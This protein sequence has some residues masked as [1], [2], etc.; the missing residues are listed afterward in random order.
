M[1]DKSDK[2]I[3]KEARERFKLAID[4]EADNRALRLEDRKFYAGDSDNCYQWPDDIAKSRRS[5]ESPRPM[6]TINKLPA[7]VKQVTNDIRQNRPQIKVRAVDDG[8]DKRTADVFNGLIRHIEANSNADYAYDTAAEGAAVDGLGYWR[9]LTE[10]VDD[11][12]MVQDIVI[13]RVR[14]SFSVYP[15]PGDEP[16]GSDMPWCFITTMIRRDEAKR[17]SKKGEKAALKSWEDDAKE[18]PQWYGDE[19]VRIAEYF[20]VKTETVKV[21]VLEDGSIV[22]GPLPDGTK[23]ARSRDAER[24]NVYWYKL[25]ADEVIEEREWPGKWIPIVRVVGEEID[26]DG[27]VIVKGLVR[28]AKDPQRQYNLSR[29]SVA[30]RINLAPKSPWLSPLAAI[31]GLEKYWEKSNTAALAYL[32]YNHVGEDGEEIPSPTRQAPPDVP[33]GFVQDAII[34]SDDLK[35]VTGQFDASMGQRS[36]ETS[37]KAIIARQKEGDTATF[38]FVDNLSRGIRHTGRILVDLVPKIYDTARVLRILGEDGSDSEVEIDPQQEKSVVDVKDASGDV[39]TIYNLGVGRFDVTV[40]TGPSFSTKRQEAAETLT[41]MTQANPQ[42]MGVIGDLMVK[43]L[44]IH[45]SD[46]MAKRLKATLVPEVREIAEMEG[47][48]SDIPPEARMAIDRLTQQLE[49]TG[50]QI[51]QIQDLAK[52]EIE[53]LEKEVSK[54]QFDVEKAELKKQEESL[55]ARKAEIELSLMK[56]QDAAQ[57]EIMQGRHELAEEREI[58]MGTGLQQVEQVITALTNAVAQMVQ[59]QAQAQMQ[60][61]ETLAQVLTVM[62]TPKQITVV[63][64]NDGLIAGATQT[65]MLQ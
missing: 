51:Q 23:A 18:N 3:I 53:K 56:T 47:K 29:S 33:V 63:R 19:R 65:P 50:Q 55:N 17:M 37:G 36:N 20:C 39:S 8:A 49:Q 48:K 5:K 62:A 46:E 61:N 44:D 40:T 35:S 34:S 57:G 59:M 52:T 21:N 45:G 10:Y 42:L 41:A 12:S 7:H 28:N 1:A 31:N 58:G 43:S 27:E 9:I 24:R 22:E 4:A 32:P 30:E 14:N 26:I 64:G 13:K 60:N 54:L 16:D 6:L 2:D 11:K 15:G 38:N 25:L